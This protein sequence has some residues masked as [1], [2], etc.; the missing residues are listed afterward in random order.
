MNGVVGVGDVRWG[1]FPKG[2]PEGSTKNEKQN[3][4]AVTWQFGGA[5]KEVNEVGK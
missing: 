3:Y 2:R 1:G 4:L 5:G